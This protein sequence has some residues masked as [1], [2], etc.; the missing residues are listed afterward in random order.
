MQHNGSTHKVYTEQQLKEAIQIAESRNNLQRVQAILD[1]PMNIT[2]M[3]D[4]EI[5][6]QA[7]SIP[8]ESREAEYY[9]NGKMVGLRK[10]RDNILKQLNQSK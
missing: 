8:A 6:D 4:D 10:Y 9:N 7:H 5:M 2:I 3:S 1:S